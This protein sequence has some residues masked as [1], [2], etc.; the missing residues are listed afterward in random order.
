[1]WRSMTKIADQVLGAAKQGVMADFRCQDP[2]DPTDLT[3]L[4][5][6]AWE[7]RTIEGAELAALCCL[8]AVHHHGLRIE[9][10]LI[11]GDVDLAGASVGHPIVLRRCV[12]EG[13]LIIRDA[14]LRRFEIS[15]SWCRGLS[16]AGVVVD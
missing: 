9:G 5:P 2:A 11:R 3:S 7:G 16:G 4:P 15:R 12:V 6:K 1:M 8:R 13:D 10:M 14:R